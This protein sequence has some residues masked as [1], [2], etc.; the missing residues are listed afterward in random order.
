[1]RDRPPDEGC[2]DAASAAWWNA[3][4]EEERREFWASLER[5][6]IQEEPAPHNPAVGTLVGDFVKWIDDCF[7][8]A[9]TVEN[10]GLRSS[11]SVLEG[12]R[13]E[14]ARRG[15]WLEARVDGLRL[16]HLLDRPLAT[17]CFALVRA[18]AI[19]ATRVESPAAGES[20]IS[21]GPVEQAAPEAAVSRERRYSAKE[22]VG[23]A[24]RSRNV[25]D[26]FRQE[27]LTT[28][29]ICKAC[30]EGGLPGA[31]KGGDG[32]WSIPLQA[33][34]RRWRGFGEWI[35]DNDRQGQPMSDD[36]ELRSAMVSV[37][38]FGSTR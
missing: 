13:E 34:E 28:Q 21:Q 7:M 31:E 14:L 6:M 27:S 30:R 12:R 25:G 32:Q 18:A 11:A 9:H 15:A 1:V 2:C 24:N 3:K 23:L 16:S 33:V 37:P 38:P 10:W 17:S 4:T 36:A 29:A 35:R 26:F 20:A 19:E 5:A 22:L 8:E